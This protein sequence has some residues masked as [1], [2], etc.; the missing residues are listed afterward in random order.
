MNLQPVGSYEGDAQHY[1]TVQPGGFSSGTHSSLRSSSEP[2]VDQ[3]GTTHNKFNQRP[4]ARDKLGLNV[5][6]LYTQQLAQQI[7]RQPWLERSRLTLACIP[8]A[9]TTLHKAPE[10]TRNTRTAIPNAL[11]KG[12]AQVEQVTNSMTM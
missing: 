9:R 4:K 8:R 3:H 12:R 10:P 1:T 2:R 6:L 7:Q 5:G 11:M